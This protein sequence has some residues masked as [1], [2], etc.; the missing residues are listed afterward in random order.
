MAA[1]LLTNNALYYVKN[2]VIS[3]WIKSIKARL[4]MLSMFLS[5]VIWRH[6]QCEM[7]RVAVSH[8]APPTQAKVKQPIFSNFL[9][10]SNFL[11]F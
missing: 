9:P 1:W 6:V 2:K 5:H 7:H 10:L 11:L 8:F 4:I 3:D